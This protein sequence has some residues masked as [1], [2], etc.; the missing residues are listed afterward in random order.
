MHCRNLHP[1]TTSIVS[2]WCFQRMSRVSENAILQIYLY[3][4]DYNPSIAGQRGKGRKRYVSDSNIRIKPTSLIA[5]RPP[6]G[7]ATYHCIHVKTLTVKRRTMHREVITTNDPT[8]G[9]CK[10]NKIANH[11]TWFTRKHQIKEKTIHSFWIVQS[12]AV[13]PEVVSM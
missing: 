2:H 3:S 5:C 8:I 1:L 6:L 7:I 12:L 4:F 13:G 9:I 10:K 11:L